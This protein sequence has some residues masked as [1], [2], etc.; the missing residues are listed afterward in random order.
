M[1][2]L[3][4]TLELIESS[5]VGFFQ[6]HILGKLYW[7]SLLLLTVVIRVCIPVYH[8]FIRCPYRLLCFLA[9]PVTWCVRKSRS[10]KAP[11]DVLA[12]GKTAGKAA[13]SGRGWGAEESRGGAMQQE[14]EDEGAQEKLAAHPHRKRNR[15]WPSHVCVCV[16]IRA[17]ACVCVCARVCHSV[18]VR[19]R[20][21]GHAR[22]C[23]RRACA[24]R[25]RRRL[26]MRAY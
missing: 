12:G 8:Y 17:R 6:K 22:V 10:G 26:R 7:L 1:K 13:W 14:D 24:R 20:G 2:P 5:R 19:G 15:R 21:R 11:D 16:C 9:A 4:E 3:E 18:C 25:T 23:V